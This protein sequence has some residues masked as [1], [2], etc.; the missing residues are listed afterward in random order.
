MKTEKEKK[1]IITEEEL[2]SNWNLP[3]FINYPFK[4]VVS[5]IKKEF[6]K[7]ENDLFL[8]IRLYQEICI[9]QK[10]EPQKGFN[11]FLTEDTNEKITTEEILYLV[12]NIKRLLYYTCEEK[13]QNNKLID[14][15][16]N[17]FNSMIDENPIL[18][19]IKKNFSIFISI[20]KSGSFNESNK[21]KDEKELDLKFKKLFGFDNDISQYLEDIKNNNNQENNMEIEDETID[22]NNINSNNTDNIKIEIIN[23]YNYILTTYNDLERPEEDIISFS[24]ILY[25]TN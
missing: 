15:N 13:N 19:F 22:A 5:F 1:D 16:K 8:L 10:D 3:I 12:Q 14:E 20:F 18:M 9:M 17:I 21:T 24:Q 7:K 4:E 6:Y 25:Y 11:I 2:L 23:I